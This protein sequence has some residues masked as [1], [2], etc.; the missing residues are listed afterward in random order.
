M[1]QLLLAAA[2][3]LLRPG[4]SEARRA[5]FEPYRGPV[6]APGA[7]TAFDSSG[8][9][10]TTESRAGAPRFLL[11]GSTE[12][13][14]HRCGTLQ[15]D[16][17]A[18]SVVVL[19]YGDNR[20]GFELMT[21]AWGAQAVLAGFESPSFTQFLYGIANIPVALV[22]SFVPKLDGFRDLY[23]FLWT[24]QYAGGAENRV[25][26]ALTR[27][28][29]RPPKVS[30]VVQTGDA[31][32][33]GRRG[34]QWERFVGKHARLRQA[35]PYLACP[36]N[37]ERMHDAGARANWDA[38]MGKPPRPERYWFA[39]DF[40][41]NIARFVFLDSN[42]LADPRDNY[43]D[44]LERALATEQLVWADSALAVPAR[45][46]F[47]VLH[48][49]LVTSGHYLSDWQYDDS[50]PTEL[51]RRAQLLALCRRRGVTAVLAGHE[52]LYQRTYVRGRDGRGFWH[53]ASGGGG[54][55]LNRISGRERK[56]ALAVTLPDSSLVTWNRARSVYNFCRL[57]IVRR[58]PPS[59]EKLMLD[60]YAVKGNGSLRHIDHVDLDQP[61][62][63]EQNVPVQEQVKRPGIPL[64]KPPGK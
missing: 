64:A 33:N 17:Q 39:V 35:V 36:G 43:P 7:I 24:H 28:L 48:H 2:L 55:P 14:L 46:K 12:A 23:S 63:P 49:P 19:V 4:E 58:P 52:H 21:T 38:V 15:L 5:L 53:V 32:E 50:R 37:H 51:R 40:P 29:D 22:Q 6:P 26:K 42:V 13:A 8:W 41:E 56:L 54:S 61:P 30:F 18:D 16:P 44:S 34:A 1:K 59:G 3:L 47:V 60:A 20:P 25:L 45:Y 31:V 10:P 62:P 57:T 27:E 11:P 9:M